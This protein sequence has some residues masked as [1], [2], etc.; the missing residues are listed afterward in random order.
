MRLT[1]Y[2]DYALRVLLYLGTRPEGLASIGEIARAYGVSQNH[3]MKVVNDLAHAGYV[4]SVRGRSGGIRL[5]MAPAEINIGAVVRH[6]EDGF[7]VVDCGSCIIA[8]VCGLTRV[9]DDAVRA[10]LGVLDGYTLADLLTQ[11]REALGA[12]FASAGGRSG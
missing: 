12:I 2:T 11:R 1:R 10:F 9:L 5:G 8:P 3:L 4:A 7:E 6:T